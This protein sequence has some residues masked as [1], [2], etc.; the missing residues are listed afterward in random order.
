MRRLLLVIM[1]LIYPFQ[2][3]LAL[4]DQ[5]CVMTSSGLTH[6]SS[7][8]GEGGPAATPVFLADDAG[9]SLADSHCPACVFGQVSA[10]S[11]HFNVPPAV[12]HHTAAV[13][14]P[15]PFLSSAPRSRPERPN[16]PAT[17]A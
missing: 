14:S 10:V 4:A 17:A 7:V 13:T 16:W 2:V 1:L 6:H 5:C 9:A 3:S 11:S 8:Q 15:I 12:A